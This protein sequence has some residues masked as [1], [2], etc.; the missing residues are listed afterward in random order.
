MH[1]PKNVTRKPIAVS[2]M[3]MTSML[4][5]LPRGVPMPPMRAAAGIPSVR[6]L[7]KPES[8]LTP[9]FASTMERLMPTKMADAARSAMNMEKMPVTIMRPTTIFLESPLDHFKTAF[10]TRNGI[11]VAMTAAVT[12][13]MN[14]Q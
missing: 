5:E 3:F 10:A 1:Q 9:L 7:P 8:F 4:E 11:G 13:K 6:A 2:N 12:A 14:R